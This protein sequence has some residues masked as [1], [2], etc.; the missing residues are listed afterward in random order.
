MGI[1]WTKLRDLLFGKNLEI[2]LVGLEN[3]GKTTFANHLAYGEPKS[4]LPTIGVNVRFVKNKSNSIDFL[5]L[6]L[7]SLSSPSPFL[8]K[9]Y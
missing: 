2:A 6:F 5:H 8:N 4:T 1:L 7:I 3:S 9:P